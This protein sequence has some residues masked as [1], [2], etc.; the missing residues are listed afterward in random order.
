MQGHPPPMARALH[1]ERAPTTLFAPDASTHAYGGYLRGHHLV[2]GYWR[3][4]TPWHINV[5]EVSAAVDTVLATARKGDLVKILVHSTVALS[6][7]TKQGGKKLEINLL[8]RPF[9]LW[10]MGNQV[11][12]QVEWVPSRD[13][14]ANGLPCWDPDMSEPELNKRSTYLSS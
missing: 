7:L 6:S 11:T 2:H 12:F 4:L 13:R 5:K 10:A 3:H 8:M 9:P 1:V 14:P